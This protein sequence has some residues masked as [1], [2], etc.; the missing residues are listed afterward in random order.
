MIVRLAILAT[1]PLLLAA[2]ASESAPGEGEVVNA[3]DPLVARALNDP[4]MVDPDLSHRNEAN[5][6]ITISHDHALP[7]F[8]GDDASASAAREEARLELLEEGPMEELP[9][10]ER[11]EGLASLA[12]VWDVEGVLAALRVPAGCQKP[13]AGSFAFAA[14]M[15]AP[16][17]IMPHGMVRVAAR[18]GSGAC[19]LQL[20]RYTTPAAIEDVLQ[21]HFSLAQRAG[22]SLRYH[23]A[24]EAIVRGK[25]GSATLEVHARPGSGN[26]THVDL[27][28][29][30]RR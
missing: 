20:V 2:C 22:F 23:E 24:P 17:R 8:R 1:I 6:A 13:I 19:S 27:A 18:A 12:E 11:G 30:R 25:L 4:L 5:A 26:L 28:H 15:P 16:A 9:A 21:Y 10:P 7:S 3:V 14:E 29:W